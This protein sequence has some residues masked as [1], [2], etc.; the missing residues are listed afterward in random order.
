MNITPDVLQHPT[1]NMLIAIHAPVLTAQTI[2]SNHLCT[3]SFT[4]LYN[5]I[6]S[7]I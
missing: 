2:L 3:A 7:A 6:T 1:R 5:G 4:S